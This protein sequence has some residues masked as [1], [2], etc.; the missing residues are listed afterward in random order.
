MQNATTL[1][2]EL[3]AVFQ[4]LKEGKIT[5]KQASEFANLAGKMIAS[6]KAQVEYYALRKEVPD[7]EFLASRPAA[8]RSD[9]PL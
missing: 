1:R 5:V 3:S 8:G 9:D 6:A 4:D 7:I 2:A